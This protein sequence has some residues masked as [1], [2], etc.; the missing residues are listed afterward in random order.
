MFLGFI[1]CIYLAAQKSGRLAGIIGQCQKYPYIHYW[2]DHET[3]DRIKYHNKRVD[4]INTDDGCK[5]ASNAI[6]RAETLIEKTN[7]EKLDEQTKKEKLDKKNIFAKIKLTNQ[8]NIWKIFEV[9]GGNDIEVWEQ[10]KEEYNRITNSIISCRSTPEKN[11]DGFYECSTTKRII[12]QNINDI[13]KLKSQKWSSLFQLVKN[14]YIY[15]RLFVGYPDLTNPSIYT[16]YIKYVILI[17][18]EDSKKYLEEYGQ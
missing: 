3:F 9:I 15:A 14:K 11:A 13:R 2:T 5:T 10:V 7:K 12:V 17:E 8:A 1:L 18:D 16:I 4:Y 6:K